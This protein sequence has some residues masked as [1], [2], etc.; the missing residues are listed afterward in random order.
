VG[1]LVDEPDETFTV[2]LS[3]PVGATIGTP[4][5]GTVTVFDNDPMPELTAADV[6]VNEAAGNAEVEL[7]LNLPSGFDVTIDYA[8][9]DGTAVAPA[10]YL[11]VTDTA[12]I[13][14]GTT[15]T[16]V[17]IPIVDDVE[18]EP[19]EFFTLE[20]TN[21]SNAVL[22][23]PAATV[24]IADDDGC[25]I[26]GDADGNCVVDAADIA[27]IIA[28]IDDP[29]IPVLGDPDC[30]GSGVINGWDLVCVADAMVSP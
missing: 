22:L 9:A 6:M 28:L 16:V 18:I 13:M 7:L 12:S 23:T 10:D 1:D 25:S 17:T 4:S 27:L 11:A 14:K 2:E 30:D 20:L 24:T 19:D 3:N 21:P 15:S 8:T 29:S 5:I 26:P